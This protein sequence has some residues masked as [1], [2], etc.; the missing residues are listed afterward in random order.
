MELSQQDRNLLERLEQ[1]LWREET[2]F[3]I[4]LMKEII[5]EDFIEFGK[6][7]CIYHRSDA[8]SISAQPIEAIIPFPDFEAR[9]L[10][11]N[12]A[13]VTYNSAVTYRGVIN[14]ARRSSIW[15]RSPSPHGWILRF[16]QGTPY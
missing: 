1:S 11:E 2:R 3:D 4:A 10:A 14:R 15:T 12:V 5:A 6:S 8:L 7:G 13:Q 9:L 16:H